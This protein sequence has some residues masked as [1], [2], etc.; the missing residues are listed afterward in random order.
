MLH[1]VLK[2]IYSLISTSLKFSIEKDNFKVVTSLA[3]KGN[4]FNWEYDS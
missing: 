2:V 4:A 3:I 1:V